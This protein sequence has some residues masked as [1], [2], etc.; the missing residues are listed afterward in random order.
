MGQERGEEVRP[1]PTDLVLGPTD[2][3]SR[4]MDMETDINPID[5]SIAHLLF[6][7]PSVS[8][9][10]PP[11]DGSSLNSQTVPLLLAQLFPVP[12]IF[13]VKST[14]WKMANQ[15][16]P[17][18]NINRNAKNWTTKVKVLGK[19][20][21][22]SAQCSPVKY[23]KLLLADAECSE[24][25]LLATDFGK[26]KPVHHSEVINRVQG[27]W[28]TVTEPCSLV[29]KGKKMDSLHSNIRDWKASGGGLFYCRTKLDIELEGD[30]G[31]CDE[32]AGPRMEN[33]EFPYSFQMFVSFKVF[34]HAAAM[35]VE[36]LNL[37]VEEG[38]V[39]GGGCTI[40]RLVSKVDAIKDSL[41]NDE[42]KAGRTLSVRKWQAAFIPDGYLDI[43]RTLS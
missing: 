3:Y 40:L 32:A 24:G 17:I 6:H 41:E 43:G 4:F 26:G 35:T 13:A 36:T 25:I 39:R 34:L 20:S 42:E 8:S 5:R 18:K 28:K 1:P 30:R 38:I 37:A 7:R 16:T 33:Y 10:V 31:D 19:W 15:L 29:T 27:Y 9:I 14:F 2:R 11:H 12:C 21:P 22:R 23:Q